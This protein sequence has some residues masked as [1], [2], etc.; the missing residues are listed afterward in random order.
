M[1]NFIV[2]DDEEAI[3]NAIKKL[4]TKI[5]FNSTLEYKV[6]T[7]IKYNKNF[8]DIINKDLDNKIYILDIEVG[9]DS[10]L[11]IAKIIRKNDPISSILILTAHAELERV[12]F[13]SRILL[14]DFIS[15]FE[16]YENQMIEALT[17]CVDRVISMNKLKIRVDRKYE[18]IEYDNILYL[19]YDSYA[20]KLRIVTKEKEYETNSSLK[21]LYEKLKGKFI[22][23]HRDCI[24]N[25]QN[26]KTFDLI[27]RKI[28]FKNNVEINLLSRR[29]IKEVKEYA[30]S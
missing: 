4:I 16:L 14:F 23:T 22:Y 27:N 3:V 15:K 10:G 25:L 1:I 12:A 7:F 18:Q 29:Y 8:Y 21:E 17:L 30:N 19:T 13:K 5:M 20:R 11:D 28:I 2:C 26:V 6:H 24:V 9:K